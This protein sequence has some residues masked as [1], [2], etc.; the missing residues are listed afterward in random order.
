V[1]RSKENGRTYRRSEGLAI[2]SLEMFKDGTFSSNKNRLHQVD[3]QGLKKLTVEIMAAGLQVSDRNPIPGLEGR[4]NLLIR[5]ADALKNQAVFG[6][7]ARP[8]NM[9]GMSILHQLSP[10]AD[11]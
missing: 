3:G 8:G 1:Y 11:I 5:L 2:A 9:L 10:I 7:D 6:A 4:T